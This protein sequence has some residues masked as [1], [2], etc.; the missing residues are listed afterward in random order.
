MIS[1]RLASIARRSPS[2]TVTLTGKP[3]ARVSNPAGTRYR[4]QCA[5]GREND[6]CA[7]AADAEDA[8]T[9]SLTRASSIRGRAAVVKI[10]GKVCDCLRLFT[11]WLMTKEAHAVSFC[12][13]SG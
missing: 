3:N 10:D 5:R 4:L 13:A 2:L 8:N 9:G 12:V 11:L 1:K 7:M 6:G